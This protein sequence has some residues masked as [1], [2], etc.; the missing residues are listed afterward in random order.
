MPDARER[1]CEP[2]KDDFDLKTVVNPYAAVGFGLASVSAV[3]QH[4]SLPE[5]CWSTWLAGLVYVW[6]CT[7]TA[8][9]QIV[10]TARSD[11][12]AYAE[13]LPFVRGIPPRFFLLGVTAIA[14]ATG[15]LAFYLCAFV[16]GFY[17]LFL[18]VFAEME[19]MALFGR[20]GFINSDFFTPVMHLAVRF[21]PMAV[22]VLIA[23]RED[24]SRQNPWRRVLLPFESEILRMHVMILALP[25]FSMIAWALFREAYQSITIVLLM[26]LFYLLPK[27]RSPD[28]SEPSEVAE[29]VGQA[30]GT[31][32]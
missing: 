3:T 28:R 29:P 31:T 17:G 24:L 1:S 12:A 21:W 5:F 2:S 4:W 25:V 7:L 23:N 16:F 27:K 14:L 11:Q 32:E 20:N 6:G 8:A 13:R 18:S 15:L 22:G 19:P 30:P 26:G 10:L 9:L